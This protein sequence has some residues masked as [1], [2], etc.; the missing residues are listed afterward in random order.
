MKILIVSQVFWPENFRINDLCIELVKLGHE[1]TVITGKPNYPQGKFYKGYSF[2]SKFKDSFEGAKLIRVPVIPRGNGS[3]LRLSLNYLSF[4]IL[5]SL[6]SLFHKKKY[7]FSF[8]FGVSPITAAFPAIIHRIFYKTKMIIW[9]QD[10]WPESVEVSGKLNSSLIKKFIFILVKYI[11]KQT[12]KIFIS[13]KFM[14]KSILEKLDNKHKKDIKYLPNWAENSFFEKNIEVNKYSTL[15]PNGFILMFAGNIG[16]GQDC[17]SIVKAAQLLQSQQYIKFVIL[18]NGSEKKSLEEQIKSLGLEDTIYLL[19]SYPIEEMPH[20]YAHADAMLITLRDDDLFSNIVPSKLQSYM[21]CHKPIAGMI[22]GESAEI[23]MLSKCGIVSNAGNY[24]DFAEK[25]I[26]LSK[27]P[28]SVLD[29]MGENG[30]NYS[31]QHFNK[32]NIIKKILEN[33]D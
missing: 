8:V 13:S 5:G 16:F 18:G 1:V 3:G 25:I 30:F 9:V 29:Q 14:E 15:I 7:D 24:K 4:A 10:L 23:I 22:N 26:D 21:A 28:K 12:D 11:Y 6:F 17:L 32:N 33:I 31:Q 19:G 27:Q 20:F 2:F